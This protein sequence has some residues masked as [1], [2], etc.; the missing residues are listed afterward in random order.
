MISLFVLCECQRQRPFALLAAAERP[1]RRAFWTSADVSI[2]NEQRHI[3]RVRACVGEF[4][5]AVRFDVSNGDFEMVELRLAVAS[6][7]FCVTATA[8]H[9]QVHA[10]REVC[11]VHLV[12]CLYLDRQLST[13]HPHTENI[14]IIY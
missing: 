3:D 1:P 10:T 9:I 13:H 4:N 8:E 2:L 6:C 12:Y 11:T 14:R 7:Q 5:V